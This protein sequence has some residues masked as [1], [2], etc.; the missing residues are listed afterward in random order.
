MFTHEKKIDKLFLYWLIITLILVFFIIIIG[1]LTRLTNSGLSITEWEL[2]KGILP[3]LNEKTWL[4]YFNLYKEIP[5]Y[6]LLNNDM[7]LN[8]FKI[9]FYWEYLHR[10]IARIIGIFFLIPLL[11]FYYSKKINKFYMRICF[12]IFFLILFQGIVGWFMVKSGL[13]DNITVSHYRLAI[14]LI[15]AFIIISILF[16]LI[17]NVIREKN[18]LFLNFTKNNFFYLFLIF[19][20]FIQIILGA[21]VSGLDA[22]RIYQTWPY[23][24]SSYI[25]ND[26]TF[27]NF[28]DV[29]NFNNHSLVQFYHRNFAY[30]IVIYIFALSIYILKKRLVYLFK[31]LKFLIFFLTIQIFL[32][33]STLLSNLD[34]FI[35][36]AHQISSVLLVF[37]AINLY[38]HQTK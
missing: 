24:G 17:N 34:I 38:Y 30:L 18:I 12:L 28:E 8:D 15:I 2:F 32:G 11:F 31:P 35:A 19:L 21:F 25:P 13:I 33:I 6:K 3:P 10:M 20:I 23:M 5:Q 29:I 4:I 22:G 7:N 1:G 36:S 37:S 9:I 26:I 14:H 16:W 27:Y